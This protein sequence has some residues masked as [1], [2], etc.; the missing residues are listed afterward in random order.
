MEEI[1]VK[2]MKKGDRPVS[3]WFVLWPQKYYRRV[4]LSEDN[5]QE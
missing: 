2:E 1:G 4:T 3:E 5:V